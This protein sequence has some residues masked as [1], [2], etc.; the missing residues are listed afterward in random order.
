MNLVFCYYIAMNMLFE[1]GVPYNIAIRDHLIEFYAKC[2]QSWKLILKRLM[3]EELQRRGT[4]LLTWYV[5]TFVHC[6][7][8]YTASM[9]YNSMFAQLNVWLS[10]Q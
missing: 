5:D 10:S 8:T 7:S 6:M 9:V 2:H 4:I 3:D 1:D